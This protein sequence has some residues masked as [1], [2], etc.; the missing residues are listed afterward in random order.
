MRGF[1]FVVVNTAI[2]GQ[3]LAQFDAISCQN[4]KANTINGIKITTTNVQNG[5]PSYQTFKYVSSIPIL[6]RVIIHSNEPFLLIYISKDMVDSF[7]NLFYT[8]DGSN[9]QF[10]RSQIINILHLETKRFECTH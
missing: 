6:N 3:P 4:T 2:D 1:F 9:N 5:R 10:C 7:F 8:T